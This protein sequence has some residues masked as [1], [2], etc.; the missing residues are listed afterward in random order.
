MIDRELARRLIEELL[1]AEERECANRHG[2]VVPLAVIRVTEHRL[3]WIV[4]YQSQAYLR[5]GNGNDVLAGNGPYLVDRYDGSIHFIPVTDYV[6]GLWE[7]DYEQ[8]IKP[9]GSVE[10]DPHGDIPFATEVREALGE[11]R[12]AAIRL[13]RRLVP[14]LNMAQASDYVAAIGAGERPTAEL[15]EMVRP[16]EP[17]SPRL[18]IVTITGPLSSV[19]E[20]LTQIVRPAPRSDA[21][22]EE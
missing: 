5:S 12:T 17:F 15:I 16:P 14:S 22:S 3:G 4:S 9:I 6:T 21:E 20:P 11:G 7:E 19:T 18:G 8:R 13:L 1:R 2:Q 10:N